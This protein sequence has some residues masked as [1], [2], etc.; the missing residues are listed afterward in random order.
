MTSDLCLQPSDFQ[1]PSDVV[2]DPF[3]RFPRIEVEDEGA[4]G[5]VGAGEGI[6][7]VAGAD[8]QFGLYD[9]F[10]QFIIHLYACESPLSVG[11]DHK[12][13][14]TRLVPARRSSTSA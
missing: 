12:R 10:S 11:R 8:P 9:R 3:L 1:M 5:A 2:D 6:D 14:A 13:R 7:L 4:Q